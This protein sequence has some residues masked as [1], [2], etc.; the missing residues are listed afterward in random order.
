M[1]CG[2]LA[3]D[4]ESLTAHGLVSSLKHVLSS[5]PFFIKHLDLH[6][7]TVLVHLPYSYSPSG[8]FHIK[9]I[10]ARKL[11]N[12]YYKNSSI[13]RVRWRLIVN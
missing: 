8:P 10:W 3:L 4:I 12:S 6:K 9:I 1:G 2:L 13:G 5:G 11:F 7:L